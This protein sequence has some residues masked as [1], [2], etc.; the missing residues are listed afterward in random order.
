MKELFFIHE[1][2]NKKKMSNDMQVLKALPVLQK[3]CNTPTLSDYFNETIMPLSQMDYVPEKDMMLDAIF[4]ETE[5]LYSPDTA[6]EIRNQIANFPVVETGTHLAFLRDYDSPKKDDLR[7]R[8]NQ[9]ILISASLMRQHGQKYHVGLYGSNVSLNHPCG[10]GYFQLGDDIYPVTSSKLI[11]QNCLYDAPAIKK[12]HFNETLPL[13]A[14]LKILND[15]LTPEIVDKTPTPKKE[16]LIKTKKIVNTLL[17]PISAGMLNYEGIE[18]AYRSLNANNQS[19]LKT[20]MLSLSAEA[21]KKYGYTFSDIDKQYQKLNSVFNR[22]DLN[23]PDQ[24]ALVQSQIINDALDG[25]DI[26]HISVD[27]IEVTRQFLIK[28]LENK[29]SLWYKVF[30]NPD[31]F[32][33]MHQSFIGIRG[34]WKE[35]ESPFDYIARD[36]GF[37]KG[38]SLPISAIDHKP[39]TL[40][41]L[42]K[43]KKIIP[44]SA[45]VVLLLQSCSVMAHGGFFQTTYADKIKKNFVRFLNDIGESKRA[46]QLQKLP[47]DMALLSLATERDKTGKPMK[48]S[49]I[50][51]KSLDERKKIMDNIPK[52]PSGQAV[53]TALPV[54]RQYLDTTAPGYVESEANRCECVQPVRHVEK[55]KELFTKMQQRNALGRAV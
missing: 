9:N 29:D 35:N 27:A 28:A 12:T 18:K 14:K 40:I 42:L 30:N 3:I 33:K 55:T 34:S 25:T 19:F 46:E 23:L 50:S 17:K 47:V 32:K 39:K 13:I 38:V 54:L 41:P 8:L 31:N 15:V 11:N 45:L 7:S 48:L 26:K 43:D 6:H 5:R 2:K 37:A 22:T 24:V 44:S 20:A 53:M 10:G 16:V 1:R 51:R 4:N 52:C 21:Y 36:K 49:E